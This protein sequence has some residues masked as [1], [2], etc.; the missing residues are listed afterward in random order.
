MVVFQN[1][2]QSGYLSHDNT[3]GLIT[4]SSTSL[5]KV[6]VKLQFYT[7]NAER[8]IEIGLY[9]EDNTL[10]MLSRNHISLEEYTTTFGDVELNGL[11]RLVSGTKYRFRIQS[12]NGG[13]ARIENGITSNNSLEMEGMPLPTGYTLASNWGTL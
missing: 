4:V 13:Q 6:K 3:T 10:V 11:V 7:T 9:Q 1:I 12:D 8:K 2:I 5:Y